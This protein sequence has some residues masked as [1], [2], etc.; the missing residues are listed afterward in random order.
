MTVLITGGA[1]FIGHHLAIFH[2]ERGDD[3]I[4]LDNLFKQDGDFDAEFKEL[5]KKPGIQF[6]NCD[7]TVPFHEYKEL[8]YLP[9]KFDIVYHLAAINGTR[10]FYEIPYEVARTNLLLTINLLDWLETK[11]VGRLLYSSTS[12]VYAGAETIGRLEIPTS[13]KN[14]CCFSSAN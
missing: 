3:V 9:N 12:E 6:Y 10:L 1:G 7:M 14:S 2:Q 13:E 8:K 4:I 5:I 11:R